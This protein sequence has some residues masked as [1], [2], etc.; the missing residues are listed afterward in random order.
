MALSVKLNFIIFTL[1]TRFQLLL[2]SGLPASLI[3]FMCQNTPQVLNWPSLRDI[4]RIG[5]LFDEVYIFLIRIM[6]SGSTGPK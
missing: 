2:C 1:P 4:W 6:C 3:N 5:G